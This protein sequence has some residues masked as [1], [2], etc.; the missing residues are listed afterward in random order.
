MA[1]INISGIINS[2]FE[3]SGVLVNA[4]Q[5]A[6]DAVFTIDLRPTNPVIIVQ[7]NLVYGVLGWDINDVVAIITL[8]GPEGQIYSN[9]DYAAPDIV[10]ATS[11]YLNKSIT[12]PL[13]PLTSYANILK[14]N[15]TLKISW[16]NSVL[17]EYY[18]FLKTY[19]YDLDP[20][21]IANTTVSGPYSGVLKS[22]DTTEYGNDVH[23]VIREHRVQY[24]DEL[25]VQPADVVSSNAEIQVTPIYTNEWTILINS[26]VEYRMT[27]ELRVYWEGSG[28]FTHCVFGGCIG[29]MWDAINTM[30]ETYKE[31][32]ACNLNN[33]EAY[34]KRLVILNT[35]WHLL[36]EAYW[37]GDTEAADEQAY[38][39]QEMVE[40]SGGGVCGGASSELVT[41]CP[42]WTGGGTGGTYTFSNALVEAAGNVTWGG[43]LV[44][45]TTI[46][47][48]SNEVLFSG[49]D[50][51]VTVS[52][53]LSA[54][55]GIV[56]KFNDGSLEAEVSATTDP[57]GNAGVIL[58]L[59]DIATPANSRVYNIGEGGILEAA[60][61]SAGYV[62]LSLVN[63]LYVDTLYSGAASY[64]FES[65]I[66]E[67]AG[68]VRLGGTLTAPALILSESDD[69]N[70]IW[71]G[72]S[73]ITN[74]RSVRIALSSGQIL[75]RSY[76][77]V[78]Y[79]GTGGYSSISQANETIILGSYTGANVHST[80]T[81]SNTSMVV[82]DDINSKGLENAVDYSLQ[83]TDHSLVTK[84][85]VEDNFAGGT[86]ITDFIDLDD[87]PAA[88]TGFGE[89]FVRV[90]TGATALEFVAAA[91][92]P[93]TGGTFTG[94][95]TI[96]TSTDRPLILQQI[97][98]GSTPGTPE[99]GLN[100]IAFQDN[101]GD[102]QGYV[103][104]DASGNVV[105]K[106]WVTGAGILADG[107]VEINGDISVTGSAI[108][109]GLSLDA[110]ETYVLGYN[111]TSGQLS[112]R[113]VADLNAY[114]NATPVP[115]ELGGIDVGTTFTAQTMTEMFDQLLYPYQ[116]PAF[117]SFV[118]SGQSTTLEC[119]V[120]IAAGVKTWTWGTSNPTN[121]ETNSIDIDDVTDATN[122]ITGTA[123]D[124]TED[125]SI[126]ASAITKTATASEHRW[127]I[128]GTNSNIE[129]FTRDF[130]V[131]WYS[132]FYYGV[133]AV[134]LTVAQVQQL[135]KQVVATGDKTYAFAPTSQ[136][137][138]FAYPASYG[139][140]SSI[141]DGNG[142]ETINDW[143]KRVENFT[144]NSP[145]YEGTT[146]SYHIYE[147][148]NITSLAQSY[149]FKF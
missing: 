59:T 134:S 48:G 70:Y 19:Q 93:A 23:Q 92:V 16:W 51:G 140:L 30:L 3:T 102:E 83:W 91:F 144:N 74:D 46:N 110:A 56:Q 33:Q 12:L 14:G 65:G 1:I 36:N 88:Y 2:S 57:G 42:P 108:V 66:T 86:L 75:Q 34:Q 6:G 97:G 95:V 31:A 61:Y 45:A 98:A 147:F 131:R 145:W 62:N 103:G 20:A 136:V 85:W 94:Q 43:S 10:P 22:T 32:M 8:V 49:V 44:Q 139:D 11:R 115:E 125:V 15:Y 81:V 71:I 128:T 87:T 53:S 72:N 130:V 105:L 121:I 63:K 129:D 127:R 28:E 29:A 17:D 137:Q 114:T 37:S 35:A 100:I 27:D 68:V 67:T 84:K 111:T 38:V 124:G 113:T 143:T 120:E 133:G 149:Q 55:D 123:N 142:F 119:G 13:D 64:T 138:Y 118:I 89:Y 18:N 107:N 96:A 146:V 40:Y 122:L 99:G 52:Q 117:T 109:E 60:D 39:I 106:S 116:Y 21:T 80:I 4:A 112:Y 47:M 82:D 41:P 79:S 101:D 76:V 54:T 126:G 73:D 135:T 77:N 132:P 148:D 9:V 78:D 104:I 5:S 141:L 58:G 26:F 90:N 25:A 69:G 7:D 24:P 50:G